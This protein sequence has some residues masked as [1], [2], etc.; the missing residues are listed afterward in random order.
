MS[1]CTIHDLPV[2][3]LRKVALPV[4]AL[5]GNTLTSRLYPDWSIFSRLRR[6]SKTFSTKLPLQLLVDRFVH[7][8]AYLATSQGLTDFEQYDREFDAATAAA[9]AGDDGD[10]YEHDDET[11]SC[12]GSQ[13]DLWWGPEIPR[14]PNPIGDTAQESLKRMLM[15]G[16]KA[17]YERFVKAGLHELRIRVT[18]EYVQTFSCT[19]L[20]RAAASSD[21]LPLLARSASHL[22]PARTWNHEPVIKD[23]LSSLPLRQIPSTV[24]R[25]ALDDG[26][27]TTDPGL[28]V[29]G[30]ELLGS[31]SLF[32]YA[33]NAFPADPGALAVS[34]SDSSPL[35]GLGGGGSGISSITYTEGCMAVQRYTEIRNRP[36]LVLVTSS[37]NSPVCS[38]SP[39][40]VSL[41]AGDPAS[42]WNNWGGEGVNIT[43]FAFSIVN[44]QG[45]ATEPPYLAS[46]TVASTTLDALG[47]I[48]TVTFK[49]DITPDAPRGYPA[50]SFL[51][52]APAAGSCFD[53]QYPF[54]SC[55]PAPVRVELAASTSTTASQTT[56]TDQ[57]TKTESDT[58]PT[59]EPKPPPDKPPA[60]PPFPR[61]RHLKTSHL[62]GATACRNLRA[63]PLEFLL[64][65]VVHKQPG[66]FGPP[67]QPI[68]SL[69][70]GTAVALLRTRRSMGPDTCRQN[71]LR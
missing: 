57:S 30:I 23:R 58:K 5:A 4:T 7:H 33:P 45:G 55:D 16:N 22:G 48:D 14:A 59:T 29:T 43:S 15:T 10:E 21:S 18:G 11:H 32:A 39:A 42:R 66:Q 67:E 8:V 70:S 25:R 71:G 68:R 44:N 19:T 69:P 36:A 28:P 54:G 37:A 26:G 9:T 35:A 24:E 51:R 31:P 34:C 65:F 40:L 63:A 64:L 52:I 62:A 38:F 61:T 2:E 47:Y 1:G 41:V 13:C 53:R 6:T 20:L 50:Q 3:I 49:V 12:P 17:L 46:A 27:A 56:T 60:P